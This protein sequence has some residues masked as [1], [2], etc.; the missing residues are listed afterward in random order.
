VIVEVEGRRTSSIS[1]EKLKEAREIIHSLR[2][3]RARYYTD[4]AAAVELFV[5]NAK[6]DH[7]SRR[8]NERKVK[9]FNQTA[10]A[11]QL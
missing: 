11:L 3:L 8:T 7:E 9:F 6:L 5:P 10:L 4:W 1:D 2:A